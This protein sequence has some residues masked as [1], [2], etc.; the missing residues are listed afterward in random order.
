MRR[1]T[2]IL[3]LLLLACIATWSLRANGQTCGTQRW[4]VK[5]LQDA[6]AAAIDFTKITDTTV[7]SMVSLPVPHKLPRNG[8]FRPIETTVFRL[9]AIRLGYTWERDRDLHVIISDPATG[10][11]MVAEIPAPECVS[12]FKDEFAKARKYASSGET[13]PVTREYWLKKPEDVIVVGV[14]F[15][16]TT[17]GRH[18][19]VGGYHMV[20]NQRRPAHWVAGEVGAAP[21]AIELHPVILFQF[22]PRGVK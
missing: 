18:L 10:E 3:I 12:R 11:T 1:T 15:F 19:E 6:D 2:L 17:H 4:N 14:G 5:T 9:H 16:D 20:G 7:H 22:D 21:N 13:A 8:R